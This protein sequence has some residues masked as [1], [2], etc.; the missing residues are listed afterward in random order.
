M[1]KSSLIL[2]STIKTKTS[3][4]LKSTNL[5]DSLSG[6]LERLKIL[7]VSMIGYFGDVI[8]ETN[9]QRICTF[10]NMKRTISANYSEHKRYTKKSQREF[11]GPKNQTVS[12]KMKFVAG[13]GVKPWDMVHEITLCCEQGKVCPFVIGGHKVGGGKWTIDSIDED[14]REVWNR[15][16]LVSVEISVTATEYY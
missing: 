5:F 16:E 8:F 4:T 3:N 9:D 10:N 6:Q 13:H 2:G 1:A 11:D 14:Y 12:F 7:P 15:G